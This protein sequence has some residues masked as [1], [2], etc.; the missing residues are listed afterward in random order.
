MCLMV[1]ACSLCTVWVLSPLASLL[2]DMPFH[3]WYL[4]IWLFV[5]VLHMIIHGFCLYISFSFFDITWCMY[6]MGLWVVLWGGL[7]LLF[8]YHHLCCISCCPYVMYSFF[9]F[10]LL[11][12]FCVP[13]SFFT[14][15]P[16]FSFVL[17][18]V[19]YPCL[20]ENFWGVY[21]YAFYHMQLYVDFE[22]CILNILCYI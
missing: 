9:F 6:Y 7:I 18:C 15:S 13:I 19:F 17:L 14:C 21:A 20:D 4:I 5:F 2:L 16:S 10:L 1:S 8:M 22:M 3:V 12:M 11:V